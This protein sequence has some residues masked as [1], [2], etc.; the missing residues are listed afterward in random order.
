MTLT[1]SIDT[2]QTSLKAVLGE[3]IQQLDLA[4]GELTLTVAAKDYV[5]VA[6]SL[7]DH[8]DLAFEQLL[9]LCGMDYSGYKDGVESRYSHSPRFA[10]VSHLLSL[11]H[12][13]RLRLRVFAPHED[14]PQ[15]ASITPIGSS[16]KLSICSASCLKTTLICAASSPITVSLVIP[17]AKTSPPA[18]MS[19][20]AMTLSKNAS[21]TN[22]SPSSRVKSRRASC[23][24]TTTAACTETPWPIL[25][26]TP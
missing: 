8:P 21:S 11:T 1:V 17:F 3:R 19:K 4:L 9:D 16:A 22:R 20:C 13:R 25:K 15:V 14:L 6:H 23:A 5:Q 24:K 18:V 12:N 10:V 26:I 2:L 7:R